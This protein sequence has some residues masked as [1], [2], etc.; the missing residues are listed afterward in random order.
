MYGPLRAEKTPFIPKTNIAEKIKFWDY[1]PAG[2]RQNLIGIY[3][4]QGT[5]FWGTPY[6]I[7]K[8]EKND[9]KAY[10][11]MNSRHGLSNYILINKWKKGDIVKVSFSNEYA[12]Y[13]K[14]TVTID[15]AGMILNLTQRKS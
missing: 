12:D 3:D 1:F 9:V 6:L 13:G 10:V 11:Y 15:P 7:L 4:G 2:L 14:N 8:G 5:D